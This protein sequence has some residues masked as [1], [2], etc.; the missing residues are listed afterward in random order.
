MKNI[1]ICTIARNVGEKI[2]RYEA[3]LRA[4]VEEFKNEYRFKISIYENDST[5][6]T[7]QLLSNIDFSIFE[8]YSLQIENIRTNY[9]GSVVSEERVM[10]LANARNKAIFAK[11]GSLLA[12]SDYILFVE[13][14]IAFNPKDYRP[15]LE[16][17][18]TGLNDIDILSGV[19]VADRS[20]LYDTWAT[21]QNP[22]QI[23][24]N[25]YNDPSRPIMPYYS[26]FN[27]VCLYKSEPF[28]KGVQFHWF[29]KT[30]NSFD[31]DTVVICDE[32][33]RAG[34]EKIFI[35]EKVYC[36]QE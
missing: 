36:F 5:D 16:F 13:S 24:G 26:T 33:R 31:C 17:K 6:N 22:S 1:L 30:I 20:R 23:W 2:P 4:L 15:I 11:D 25:I 21:R 10:N 28:K 19:S 8:D 34:Y 14:D 18:S 29:N 7:K 27:C 32:F 12:W 35:N 9:I 3:Q